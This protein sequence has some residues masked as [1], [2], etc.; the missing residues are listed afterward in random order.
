MPGCKIEREKTKRI[1]SLGEWIEEGR[2]RLHSTKG[3]GC[4]QEW[5]REH[6]LARADASATGRISQLK[7]HH[8][9]ISWAYPLLVPRGSSS[10][11]LVGDSESHLLPGYSSHGPRPACVTHLV[12]PS[13][14]RSSVA[15]LNRPWHSYRCLSIAVG[16][17][18]RHWSDA[19]LRSSWL[20]SSS[21]SI[22]H[23]T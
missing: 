8:I 4:R 19:Q 9:S 6:E 13:V 22:P 18:D 1:L 2:L 12:L 17:Q 5:A 21:H 14:S 23:A 20:V 10:L 7:S 3:N 15:F 11:H 16:G